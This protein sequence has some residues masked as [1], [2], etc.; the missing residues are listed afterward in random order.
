VTTAVQEPIGELQ[1]GGCDEG[2]G[3]LN[4]NEKK[5][6]GKE[7]RSAEARHYRGPLFTHSY[8]NASIGSSRAALRAG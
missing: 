7:I 4:G 1:T 6:L 5:N 8:R 2:G 3:F